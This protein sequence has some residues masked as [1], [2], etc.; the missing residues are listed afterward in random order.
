MIDDILTESSGE[1]QVP[2]PQRQCPSEVISEMGAP[3]LLA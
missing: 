2:L 1:D 3:A